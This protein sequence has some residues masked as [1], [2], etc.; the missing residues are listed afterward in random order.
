MKTYLPIVVKCSPIRKLA[1]IPFEKSPDVIYRGFELQFI[2]GEPYG[3]GYRVLAYRND[4]YVDVYDDI[5]LNFLENEKFNVVEN[6]LH[7]HIQTE[8][9]NVQMCRNGNNQIISFQFID[10]QNRKISVHIE[11]NS[12]KT[13]KSMNLLAPIGVG[14]KAPD[15]LPVFFMYN[16]DFIRKSKSV[17]SCN[18][19]GKNIK[20]DSFLIPMN[21]QARL[22]ARYSNE[23]E[24]LEF[25]GASMMQLQE[26][27]LNE[28]N[29][30]RE[31]NVEYI[32]EGKDILKKI[33]VYFDKQNVEICFD[34]GLSLD[35]S[36]VG[37]FTIKP[38]EQMGYIKGEYSVQCDDNTTTFKMSPKYGWTSKPNSLLTKMI[39]GKY[40][41]FCSWSKRY[42]YEAIID[43]SDRKVYA[44]W[45]NGNLK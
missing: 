4:S 33:R 19:D 11:E 3:K 6:G 15:Y 29:T 16:F 23:C 2:E 14:S 21:C 34:V 30:Y 20:I 26:V 22:Y 10:I 36:G 44:S 5:G 27:E 45:K 7:K 42:R 18:I 43:L 17:A 35:K 38:R 13:S 32:F 12:K 40:S 28:N 31:E 25:A 41:V 37:E 9:R 1:L 8:I 39:L 24:L